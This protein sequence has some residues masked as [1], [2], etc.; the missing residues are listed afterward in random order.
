MAF[1]RNDACVVFCER[2][3]FQA[4]RGTITSIVPPLMIGMLFFS[5]ELGVVAMSIEH[6]S[7]RGGGSRNSGNVRTSFTAGLPWRRAKPRT[8]RSST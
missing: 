6:E 4:P 3:S 7:Q 5:L 8:I 2:N 1:P